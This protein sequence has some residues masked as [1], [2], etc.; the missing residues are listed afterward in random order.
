MA[1]VTTIIPKVKKP[2]LDDV[3]NKAYALTATITELITIFFFSIIAPYN[4]SVI[5]ISKK[6]AQLFG[7]FCLPKS[8]KTCLATKTASL[9][10][11]LKI[12][13][14]I[15]NKKLIPKHACKTVCKKKYSIFCPVMI[16][17]NN[18]MP[19]CDKICI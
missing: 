2:A 10:G 6:A 11:A 5:Q 8:V 19:I 12:M 3:N 1:K 13:D 9:N 15:P 18:T 7:S 16:T 17:T 4:P 14:N